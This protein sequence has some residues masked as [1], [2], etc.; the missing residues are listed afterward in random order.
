[1]NTLLPDDKNKTP[2]PDLREDSTSSEEH[3][4]AEPRRGRILRFPRRVIRKLDVI[5][6]DNIVLEAIIAAVA[7]ALGVG[8]LIFLFGFMVGFF[9][10]IFSG[11][12]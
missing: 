2:K 12:L 6:R 7:A 10:I 11:E 3:P 9:R 1:M 5:G 8:C 4:S